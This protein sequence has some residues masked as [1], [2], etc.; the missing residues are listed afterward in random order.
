MAA[1]L[2]NVDRIV[3]FQTFNGKRL[4]QIVFRKQ[5]TI[6]ILFFIFIDTAFVRQLL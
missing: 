1:P 2:L 4:V 3:H 5:Q 6:Q